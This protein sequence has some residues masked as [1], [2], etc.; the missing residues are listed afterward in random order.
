[1]RREPPPPSKEVIKGYITLAAEYLATN[2]NFTLKIKLENRILASHPFVNTDTIAVARGPIIYCVEDFDNPWVDDHFKSLQLDPDAVVT[3]RAVK[4]PPTG[5]EY[6]ALEVYRGASLLPIESLKAVPSVPW[7]TLSKAAAE[8]EGREGHGK[9]G[10]K[11]LGTVVARK[12][13]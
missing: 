6:V 12:H 8:A 2:P 4:D 3:E 13:T 1:C 11:A 10:D 7:K 9:D 5:E